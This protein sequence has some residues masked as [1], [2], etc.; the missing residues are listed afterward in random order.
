M[1]LPLVVPEA[2]FL[3]PGDCLP[4]LAHPAGGDGWAGYSMGMVV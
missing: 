4:R 1:I 3:V 2:H